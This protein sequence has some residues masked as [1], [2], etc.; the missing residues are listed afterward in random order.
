MYY[1]ILY[2]ILQYI[3]Y[4][5]LYYTILYYIQYRK[6]LLRR[7]PGITVSL[8]CNGD[9]S[10]AWGWQTE[11]G[12][13]EENWVVREVGAQTREGVGNDWELRGTLGAP[14]AGCLQ[15]QC[16]GGHGHHS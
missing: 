16:R 3:L 9:A 11:P 2:T 5:I 7:Q 8:D 13:T 4:L 12:K 15:V 14:A 10:E 1:T 6:I